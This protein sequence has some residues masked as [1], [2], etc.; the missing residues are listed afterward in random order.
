MADDA[1]Q[2]EPN[3]PDLSFATTDE[4]LAEID[5]RCKGVFCVYLP[6]ADRDFS[7]CIFGRWHDGISVTDLLGR[8]E[9]AKIELVY[10]HILNVEE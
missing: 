10:K 7:W 2:P 4:L 5:R 9:A 8:V 3:A 1:T 6:K